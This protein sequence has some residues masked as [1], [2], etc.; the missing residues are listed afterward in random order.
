MHAK[1]KIQPDDLD[2]EFYKAICKTGRLCLQQCDDCGAWT[3]PARYYCPHCSSG[4]FSFKP[5]SGKAEVHSWTI[6]HFSVEPGWKDE[7]PYISIV[8]ETAEG[9][10]LI[11]RTKMAAEI[12]RI[13]LPLQL[14]VEVIDPE[15]SYVWA[16]PAGE[17]K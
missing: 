9:P 14:S 7:V 10:R 13:G 6:S 2:L 5:V 4:K 11:A 8:A 12:L 16:D 15:F 17:G 1:P 3:H